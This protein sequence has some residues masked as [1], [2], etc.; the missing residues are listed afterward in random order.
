MG[1]LCSSSVSV[2][3]HCHQYALRTTSGK[4]SA[5]ICKKYTK[6]YMSETGK[7]EKKSFGHYLTYTWIANYMTVVKKERNPDDN[8]P[9]QANN[10]NVELIQIAAKVVE[11]QPVP[12]PS[13]FPSLPPPPKEFYAITIYF[14]SGTIISSLLPE[15]P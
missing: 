11:I 15:L 2:A 7:K 12:V 8:P 5:A 1:P 3:L 4:R 10:I 14:L 13:F 9:H 6:M